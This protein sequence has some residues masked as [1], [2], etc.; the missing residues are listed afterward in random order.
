MTVNELYELNGLDGSVTLKVGQELKVYKNNAEADAII[1][2]KDAVIPV[3][4]KKNKPVVVDEPTV[5]NPS[6]PVEVKKSTD[7]ESKENK[8]IV[9]TK[10]PIFKIVH[11]VQKG[12][13]IFRIASFYEVSPENLKSW[14]NLSSNYVEIGQELTIPGEYA[15]IPSKEEYVKPITPEVEKSQDQK[16]HTVKAGETAYRISI[17]YNLSV[18]QLLKINGLSGPTISV[19]QKLK[20]K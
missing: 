17:M 19:G 14:N 16:Y 18:P 5:P 3:D 11:T 15:R 4:T 7:E 1:G 2:N 13:T 10:N 20:V 9:S 6:K 8:F 12:E